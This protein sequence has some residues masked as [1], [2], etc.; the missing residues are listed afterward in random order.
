MSLP[1]VL[2]PEARQDAAEG[3]DHLEARQPCRFRLTEP[4][5]MTRTAEV[6]RDLLAALVSLYCGAEP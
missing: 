6:Q 2:R 3:R 5:L 1:V 4:C